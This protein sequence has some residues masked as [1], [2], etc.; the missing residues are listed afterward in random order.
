VLRLM[1]ARLRISF[2]AGI[3]MLSLSLVPII[4]ETVVFRT[5]GLPKISAPLSV[6]CLQQPDPFQNHAVITPSDCLVLD[7]DCGPRQSRGVSS[8]NLT[9]SLTTGAR[10]LRQGGIHGLPA[11]HAD[12]LRTANPKTRVGS[13][14]LRHIKRAAA[15]VRTQQ[16]PAL[17][18][19]VAA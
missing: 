5:G 11:N 12:R 19:R 6:L 15:M 13:A 1:T 8:S 9:G 14:D 18:A 10:N 4:Q 16:K 17:R 7:V 2:H 3:L